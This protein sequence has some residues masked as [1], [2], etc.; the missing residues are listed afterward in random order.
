MLYK[1][2]IQ[3]YLEKHKRSESKKKWKMWPS[4]I[5]FWKISSPFRGAFQVFVQHILKMLSYTWAQK[6][7]HV[8][9]KCSCKEPY[10]NQLAEK[11]RSFVI[12]E[13][14]NK[15]SHLKTFFLLSNLPF[16]SL[17]CHNLC[18]THNDHHVSMCKE[19][20]NFH[21]FKIFTKNPTPD[22]CSA[23]I[24]RHLLST[25]CVPGKV[26]GNE[27]GI[28]MNIEVNRTQPLLSMCSH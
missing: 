20:G 18:Q 9:I 14:E 19:T 4:V 7:S 15:D 25:C 12:A 6:M 13:G 11:F 1:I 8:L 27:M 17:F 23:L 16:P 26:L 3:N 21:N 5:S 28:E 2:D 10:S 22:L 24:H